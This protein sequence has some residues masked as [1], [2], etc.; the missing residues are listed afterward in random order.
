MFKPLD[1]KLIKHYRKLVDDN[2]LLEVNEGSQ[3]YTLSTGSEVI[4]ILYNPE[5]AAEI[6]QNELAMSSCLRIAGVNFPRAY[7]RETTPNGTEILIMDMLSELTSYRELNAKERKKFDEGFDRAISLAEEH[8]LEPTD[9]DKYHNCGFDR[10]TQ[11]IV[12]YDGG[13]WRMAT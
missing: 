1:P 10:K 9:L 3:G 13:S 4:K 6:L 11:E 5:K 8:G 7:C 2:V 12:F